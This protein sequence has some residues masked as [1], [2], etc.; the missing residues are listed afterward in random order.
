MDWDPFLINKHLRETHAGE[1]DGGGPLTM[2]QYYYRH[3]HFNQRKAAEADVSAS[4]I[5]AAAEGD[6]EAKTADDSEAADNFSFLDKTIEATIGNGGDGG[7]GGGE[8]DFDESVLGSA[9]QALSD[10]LASQ[11]QQT[12]AETKKKKTPS[13]AKR[14]RPKPAA[15][16]ESKESEKCDENGNSILP[17]K[18]NGWGEGVEDDT[19]VRFSQS[20]LDDEG[21]D[22]DKLPAGPKEKAGAKEGPEKKKTEEEARNGPG[23]KAKKMK[24]TSVGAKTN[25]S[26][27]KRRS[28]EDR[29]EGDAHH[30]PEKKKK[31]R[32]RGSKN[33]DKAATGS[34]SGSNGKGASKNQATKASSDTSSSSSRSRPRTGENALKERI[35]SV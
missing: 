17:S 31:K 7:G 30:P 27:T 32:Q 14:K 9:S 21:G 10:Y 6:R 25:T 16:T 2:E 12:A 28:D 19:G 13:A 29:S 1:G 4:I 26:G 22:R 34:H 8:F 35:R 20:Y 33:G 5:P 23:A 15:A 3:V 11:S 24:R 18:E